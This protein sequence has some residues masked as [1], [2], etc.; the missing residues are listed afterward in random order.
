[1]LEEASTSG[2]RPSLSQTS[3]ANRSTTDKMTDTNV[4]WIMRDCG[5]INIAED[6][7]FTDLKVATQQDLQA[8]VEVHSNDNES[9]PFS[10]MW[11][12]SSVEC[13]LKFEISRTLIF[14]LVTE[15]RRFWNKQHSRELLTESDM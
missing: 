10:R 11:S 1:M 13:S 14:G 15:T 5:L 3:L 2:Q 12:N 7:G 6:S 9:T 4:K 8:T